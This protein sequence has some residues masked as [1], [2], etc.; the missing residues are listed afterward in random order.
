MEEKVDFDT[1]RYV[2]AAAQAIGLPIAPEYRAGVVT[3]F[4]QIA[5]MAALVMSFPIDDD[6][7]PATVF[8]P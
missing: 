3:S 6:I 8:R 5:A 4:G 2:D 7:D 1:Q